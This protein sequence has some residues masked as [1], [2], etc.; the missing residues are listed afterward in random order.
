MPSPWARRPRTSLKGLLI[1]PVLLALV[2]LASLGHRLA[3][4]DA[5]R[6]VLRPLHRHGPRAR[7]VVGGAVDRRGAASAC[8][9]ATSRPTTSRSTTPTATRSRSP[10]SSSGRSPTPRR[11][12]T[13]STTTSNFVSR[14]G[15]VGAAARRHHAPLRRRRRRRARRCAARP[16]SSPASWPR[17]VAQRVLLAG[18]EIVEVRISH[19]AYASEI[20]Q[21]M[22]R[23]QQAN[24][25]VA[26]R[27]RIVEGAVGMVEM[28]LDRSA[29]ARSSSST[30]NARPRWS[31]TCM[32]VL[33]GDQPASPD[34]QH[35]ARSTR[36]VR[37]ASRYC[38]ASTPRCTTHW[39][40]GPATS[41]AASTRTSR[42]CCARRWPTPAGCRRRPA[43]CR[44][45]AA[46]RATVTVGTEAR[47]TRLGCC[48]CVGVLVV[49]V[50]GGRH[51]PP[52][53]RRIAQRLRL[54]LPR[55]RT[56]MAFG[57]TGWTQHRP[58]A[59]AHSV[60][61]LVEEPGWA[62]RT[63]RRRLPGGARPARGP[64]CRLAAWAVDFP[65][66]RWSCRA[67]G[68][69]AGVGAPFGRRAEIFGGNRET[70]RRLAVPRPPGVGGAMRTFRSRRR[71]IGGQAGADEPGCP[72]PG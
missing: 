57:R 26:A 65:R 43:S 14:A 36:D 15:R 33:C 13:P 58:T 70:W 1:L 63:V 40:G 66:R 11:P 39:R 34:R 62:A 51:S 20:A 10:P 47:R 59:V 3:R 5:G 29:S 24:A 53:W 52:P 41:S 68:R 9:C 56:R 46:R 32:V 61:A 44:A 16:T 4:P 17:E 27:S 35:R 7:A 12:S 67:S 55:T 25:V 48:W 21:A 64:R 28:A 30:R 18:V 19:L 31:A 50:T 49:G 60:T 42:C 54:H 45:A 23:R 2:V 72:S 71:D 38:C 8:G 22:L 6:A 37:T 69:Y